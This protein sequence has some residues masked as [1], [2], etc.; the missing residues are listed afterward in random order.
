LRSKGK[1]GQTI[2]ICKDKQSNLQYRIGYSVDFSK[3]Q[4][5]L[6]IYHSVI[7]QDSRTEEYASIIE[8]KIKRMDFDQPLNILYKNLE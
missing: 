6:V 2:Y 8:E 3:S 5:E 7:K 1:N 4:T